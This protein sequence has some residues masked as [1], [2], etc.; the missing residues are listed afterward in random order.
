MFGLDLV[1]LKGGRLIEHGESKSAS[2][3]DCFMRNKALF[4]QRDMDIP[5]QHLNLKSSQSTEP[6]FLP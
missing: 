3:N 6:S 2:R 1:L 5:R 4:L